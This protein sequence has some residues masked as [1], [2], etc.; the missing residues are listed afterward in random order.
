[1][2]VIYKYEL[3]S[4]VLLPKDAMVLKAGMQGNGMFIWVL[5]DPN[6]KTHIQRTFEVIGTGHPFDYGRMEYR[7][8]D[9]IFDGPFVW[10]IWEVNKN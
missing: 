10:H 7:F 3:K 4:E 9:T 8:V 1:M 6:E 2:K 5:V